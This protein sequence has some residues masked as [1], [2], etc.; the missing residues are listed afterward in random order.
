[1]LFNLRWW[2]DGSDQLL[3]LNLDFSFCLLD[4]VLELDPLLIDLFKSFL[5]GLLVLVDLMH[6]LL[7]LVVEG[8]QFEIYN[9]ELLFGLLVALLSVFGSYF[10]L[11]LVCFSLFLQVKKLNEHCF[12]LVLNGLLFLFKLD[13]L[14]LLS[15]QVW[16]ESMQKVILLWDLHEV[17]I[18]HFFA[19]RWPQLSHRLRVLPELIKHQKCVF[20]P[21]LL[22]I[23]LVLYRI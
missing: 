8:V 22:D 13:Y 10:V 3:V 7:I 23:F 15:L 12:L 19:D 14:L 18:Y 16:L 9:F 21:F 5:L 11:T 2:V 6:L 20:H 17:D 1:M 4:L